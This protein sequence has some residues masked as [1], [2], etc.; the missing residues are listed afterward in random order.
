MQDT[1]WSGSNA[2]LVPNGRPEAGTEAGLAWAGR[3]SELLV[4]GRIEPRKRQL[5]IARAAAERGSRVKFVG[6]LSES[7]PQ[8]AD[9]FMKIVERSP[10][11]TWAGVLPP[12]EVPMLMGR[13][14]VLLNMSWVE[15]QSLVD[16]EAASAGCYVVTSGTG[17]SKEWMPGNVQVVDPGRM[18]EAIKV[19]ES[20]AG[21]NTPPT[22]LQYPWTW[23][24]ATE[25]L[26]EV[27][28]SV[29]RQ[30]PISWEN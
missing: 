23:R 5:E 17:H 12:S 29:E 25:R 21:S 28:S 2:V 22:E 24:A 14:R 30:A 13:H 16:I 4:V 6:A 20:L 10:L 3:G 8:Y 7:T 27:Y 1:G 18:H 11:L 9:D 15:V 19:A 26:I